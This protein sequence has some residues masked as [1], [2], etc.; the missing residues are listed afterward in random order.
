MGRFHGRAGCVG[1]RAQRSRGSDARRSRSRIP[2]GIAAIATSRLGP[3]GVDGRA[4]TEVHRQH[5]AHQVRRFL[6]AE[7][8][9]AGC[10][11]ARD[12]YR[13][14]RWDARRWEITV[15]PAA[16]QPFKAPVTSYFPYSGQTPAAGVTGALALPHRVLA[17]KALVTAHGSAPGGAAPFAATRERADF[18]PCSKNSSLARW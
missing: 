8:K 4:G 3:A 11:I 1:A 2:A 6:A 5:G 16:G 9:A 13:L 14:P 17:R 12:S 15:T 7:F 10:E 18:A